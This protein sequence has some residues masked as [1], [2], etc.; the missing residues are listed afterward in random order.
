M[1][2]YTSEDQMHSGTERVK[3]GIK[4]SEVYLYDQNRKR[5]FWIWILKADWNRFGNILIE[6]CVEFQTHTVQCCAGQDGE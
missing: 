6:E 3:Q 4:S 5:K 1:I 2:F